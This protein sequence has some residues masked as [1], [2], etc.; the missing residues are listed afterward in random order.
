[1]RIIYI[2]YIYIF[3]FET[4]I[5]EIESIPIVFFLC[6]SVETLIDTSGISETLDMRQTNYGKER[7]L[8]TKEL[9]FES[10]RGQF[11]FRI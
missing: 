5:K 10:L 1:M 11:F 6:L 7:P 4:F 9:R 2:K 8:F 3:D